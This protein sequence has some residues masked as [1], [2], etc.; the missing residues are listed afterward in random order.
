MKEEEARLL[1]IEDS[2]SYGGCN[3]KKKQKKI[4]A[5]DFL[6]SGFSFFNDF[7][8]GRTFFFTF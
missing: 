6:G 7:N 1:K 8:S 3:P 4:K 2:S 5:M